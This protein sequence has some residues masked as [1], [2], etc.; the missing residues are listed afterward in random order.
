[1]HEARAMRG[2]T[3]IERYLVRVLGGKKRKANVSI[4]Q[5]KE[6][7]ETQNARNTMAITVY[8]SR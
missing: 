1:M 7:E 8:Y 4:R 6:E 2:H 3:G 5:H